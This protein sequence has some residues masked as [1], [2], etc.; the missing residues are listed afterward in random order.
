MSAASGELSPN[1]HSDLSTGIADQSAATILPGSSF[2]EFLRLTF[3]HH[4]GHE[5]SQDAN[6]L[7]QDRGRRSCRSQ[8]PSVTA[9]SLSPLQAIPAQTPDADSADQNQLASLCIDPPD[10]PSRRSSALRKLLDEAPVVNAS[11]TNANL[12]GAL[13]SVAASAAK[14]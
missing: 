13:W 5:N 6:Q 14:L 8:Q 1:D 7:R 4:T 12:L 9:R 10:F 2:P 3:W 11:I